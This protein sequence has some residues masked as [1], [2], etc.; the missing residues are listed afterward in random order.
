MKKIPSL[1]K[2]D[3]DGDRKVFDEV[4]EGCEWVLNGE[5]IATVKWDGTACMVRD[6]QLFKRY[7]RKPS[8]SAARKRKENRLYLFQ[9]TDLKPAPKDWAA[10]EEAP[11]IHTGHWPG[12]IPVG[13]GPQDKW[14]RAAAKN[15]CVELLKD[16]TY[17]LVGPAIQSNPHRQGKH[18]L[19]RHGAH[20]LAMPELLTFD[21]IYQGLKSTTADVEGIV[22][23]HPD[24]RMCKIK[25]TDFGLN[26]PVG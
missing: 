2:R 25:R 3:Y 4:V 11:N 9:L 1:F 7:D 26:W 12:W 20:I 18:I 8:K 23:H 19:I 15:T 5:G 24:G 14:H 10:C 13:D 22:W 21:S 16:G 17:E 6:G